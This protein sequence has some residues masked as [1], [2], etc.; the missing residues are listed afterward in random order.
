MARRTVPA[1]IDDHVARHLQGVFGMTG[2]SI[3][4]LYPKAACASDARTDPHT[5][6]NTQA[7]AQAHARCTD[8]HTHTHTHTHMRSRRQVGSASQCL[9]G[10]LLRVAPEKSCSSEKARSNPVCVC[11]RA[12]VHACVLKNC[13]HTRCSYFG[14]GAPPRELLGDVCLLPY[15]GDVCLLPYMYLKWVC[16][17]RRL[18]ISLGWRDG[19]S[20][21]I[22]HSPSAP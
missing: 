18:K 10:F 1:L 4:H 2:G 13:M 16:L 14:A 7:R 8:A 15:S 22:R 17:L 11:A 5:H 12:C 20:W 9:R 19:S 3:L 21:V 6:T